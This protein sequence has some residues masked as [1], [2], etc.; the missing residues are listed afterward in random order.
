M[1]ASADRSAADE[2]SVVERT[3]AGRTS[4]AALAVGT[5]DPRVGVESY[6]GGSESVPMVDGVH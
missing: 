3:A 4:R 2:N 1:T 6:H 5:P